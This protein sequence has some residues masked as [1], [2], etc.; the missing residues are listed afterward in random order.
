MRITPLLA[1]LLMLGGV[2]FA[3]AQ[4]GPSDGPRGASERGPSAGQESGPGS[5]AGVSKRSAGSE[6]SA[7]AS[8]KSGDTRRGAPPKSRSGQTTRVPPA[9]LQETSQ[10]AKKIQDDGQ[11]RL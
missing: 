7:G 3:S 9:A 6:E 5:D 8:D 2:S 4:E 10:E 1:A 11:I